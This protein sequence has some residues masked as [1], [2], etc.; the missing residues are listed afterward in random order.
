M[1][2]SKDII[3]K[4]INDSEVLSI[5]IKQLIHILRSIDIIGNIEAENT[6]PVKLVEISVQEPLPDILPDMTIIIIASIIGGIGLAIV[7][8]IILIRKRK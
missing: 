6:F 2:I 8:T 5:Y 3:S 1:E 7:I 4:E